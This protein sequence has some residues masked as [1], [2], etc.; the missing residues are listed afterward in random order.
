MTRTISLAVAL[1]C[2]ALL[3]GLATTAQAAER[4]TGKITKIT[5]LTEEFTL[6]DK[7]GKTWTFQ[8]EKTAKIQ[9]NDRAAKLDQL[10]V[11]D[12]VEV[13]YEK[14]GEKMRASEIRC[15]RE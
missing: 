2:L 9:L 6:T 12:E 10:K 1:L 4:A 8:V 5:A 15:K 14:V 7:A 11:G 13:T 3:L